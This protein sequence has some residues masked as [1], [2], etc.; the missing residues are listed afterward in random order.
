MARR[1][2]ERG[3]KLGSERRHFVGG[4][5]VRLDREDKAK[6][7]VWLREVR[8]A[9]AGLSNNSTPE[10][11][12]SV[13]DLMLAEDQINK[14]QGQHPGPGQSYFVL[15]VFLRNPRTFR[16][17][18][19]EEW[20]RRITDTSQIST[21]KEALFTSID[22]SL[23]Q[24]YANTCLALF[25]KYTGELFPGFSREQIVEVSK[26]AKFLSRYLLMPKFWPVP[27]GVSA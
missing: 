6:E 9:L 16:S 15:S 7:K 26:Q 21:P 27:T 8:K 13:V 23:A 22:T 3:Q 4:K 11:A 5:E 1:G 20:C 19:E 14:L 18:F 12:F 2:C 10:G 24:I 25:G 17:L